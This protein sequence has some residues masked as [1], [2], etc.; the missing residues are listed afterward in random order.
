[1]SIFHAFHSS[2]C[3]QICL[4][5]YFFSTSHTLYRHALWRI[6][7]AS[8]KFSEHKKLFTYKS[9][10]VKLLNAYY[11]RHTFAWEQNELQLFCLQVFFFFSRIVIQC[12]YEHFYV[13]FHTIHYEQWFSCGYLT[14]WNKFHRDDRFQD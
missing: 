12:D 3:V 13:K 5:D 10:H 4:F 11:L 7:S 8:R 14:E 9:I 1:M 6:L 2:Y